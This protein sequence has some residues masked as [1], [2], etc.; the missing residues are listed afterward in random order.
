MKMSITNI[1]SP[2]LCLPVKLL[3][4]QNANIFIACYVSFNNQKT[5]WMW[6]RKCLRIQYSFLPIFVRQILEPSLPKT[7]RP[8]KN[9]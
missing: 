5:P 7:N 8:R 3:W 2:F 6:W 4:A 9:E 1:E